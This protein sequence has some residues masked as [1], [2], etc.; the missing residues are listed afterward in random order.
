MIIQYDFDFSQITLLD[1]VTFWSALSLKG[2]PARSISMYFGVIG[3]TIDLSDLSI[4]EAQPVFEAFVKQLA[5]LMSLAL[6]WGE[7]CP[8]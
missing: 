2:D 5:E 4:T 3:K 8:V 7:L 1:Y 6:M